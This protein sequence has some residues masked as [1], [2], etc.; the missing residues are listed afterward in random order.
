MKKDLDLFVEIVIVPQTSFSTLCLMYFHLTFQALSF[1][2]FLIHTLG[3]PSPLAN[4]F[5]YTPMCR[6]AST[7]SL[8]QP[9]L[10]LLK[11]VVTHNVKGKWQRKLSWDLYSVFLLHL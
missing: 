8:S 3:H 5:L 1:F 2:T 6:Q 4:P 7:V 10:S 11:N 9:N